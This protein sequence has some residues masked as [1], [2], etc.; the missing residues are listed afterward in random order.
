MSAA[1]ELPALVDVEEVAVQL[2]L[3]PDH[4]RRLVRRGSASRCIVSADTARDPRVRFTLAVTRDAAAAAEALV[5]LV[6]YATTRTAPAPVEDASWGRV[7]G[8]HLPP[9][10]SA[11]QFRD[12]CAAKLIPGAVKVGRAW[13]APRHEVERWAL[14]G[15]KTAANDDVEELAERGMREAGMVKVKGAKG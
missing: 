7:D 1:H 15:A 5:A 4:V 8:A 10:I 14:D 2:D 12:A 6:D 13:T 9:W 3:H 11:E